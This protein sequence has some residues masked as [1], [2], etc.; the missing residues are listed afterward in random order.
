[1]IFPIE[2]VTDIIDASKQISDQN[3]AISKSILIIF[4]Q[5]GLGLYEIGT[6]RLKNTQNVL[7]KI[8]LNLGISG[9]IFSIFGYGLAYGEEDSL[10]DLN[11]NSTHSLSFGYRVIGSGNFALS[12]IHAPFY[13]YFLYDVGYFLFV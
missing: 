12:G 5:T 2:N 9:I 13:S 7:L 4:M 11:T 3:W 10:Q 8:L 6:V 1:M